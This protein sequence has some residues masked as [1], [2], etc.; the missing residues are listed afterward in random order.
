MAATFQ[1]KSKLPGMINL[2]LVVALGILASK[3][4]WMI[5]SPV[6]KSNLQIEDIGIVAEAQKKVIN[7]GKIIAD[8]HLFGEIKKI[9]VIKKET[10][11]APVK[12]VVTPTKLN[13][14]LHGIVAYQDK[15]GFALIS[16]SGGAQKVYGEGEEI[17]K[18][19][20]ISKIYPEKVTLNNHG[21]DEDLLLPKKTNRKSAPTRNT[22]ATRPTNL[23]HNKPGE[24][25]FGN[26]ASRKNNAEKK[27]FDIAKF[28]EEAIASPQKLMEIARPSPAMVNGQF[29]GFRVQP[30]NQRKVFRQL[31]FRPNDIITEVNGI[32]LDSAS[33]GAQV[34]AELAQA[35]SL[36]IKVTR[37]NQEVFIEHGF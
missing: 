14:K 20:T 34:L 23:L 15:K 7:Y 9:K 3:L 4:M 35:S 22:R 19:V 10:P 1:T 17:Q 13:L 16:S 31:G 37:G 12:K 18:G 24:P 33:K 36:S 30:G 2:L 11:T 27:S 26:S 8:S 25:T 32:L 6:K 5:V 21:Q 29:I 28:R